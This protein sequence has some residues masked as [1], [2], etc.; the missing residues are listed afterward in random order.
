MME[1]M[2]QVAL[3]GMAGCAGALSVSDVEARRDEVCSVRRWLAKLLMLV[4]LLVLEVEG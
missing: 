2:L 3:V 4:V 1:R